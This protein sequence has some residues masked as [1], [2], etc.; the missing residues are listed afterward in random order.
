MT[1]QTTIKKT[2]AFAALGLCLGLAAAMVPARADG[3]YGAIA[4]SASD[5]TV[6]GNA[7]D[8]DSD[9][10]A[11]AAAVAECNKGGVS[12]CK[13]EVHFHENKCGAVATDKT[14]VG[15]GVGDTK[16]EASAA[17]LAEVPSGK[18]VDAICN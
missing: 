8:Y 1:M 16:D 11:R 9:S 14:S 5:D 10:A 13:M 4:V 15:W 2:I 6:W 7:T 17:A 12:D 3:D 18:V